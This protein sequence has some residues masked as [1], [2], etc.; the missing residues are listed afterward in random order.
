MFFTWFES[1]KG[2][3]GKIGESPKKEVKRKEA[4]RIK[5]FRR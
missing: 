3:R 5:K 2:D 4:R 1:W